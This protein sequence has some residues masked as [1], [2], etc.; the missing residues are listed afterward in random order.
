VVLYIIGKEV[1]F[2]VGFVWYGTGR[3]W[4]RMR[5][6]KEEGSMAVEGESTARA[7]TWATRARARPET[8]LDG[9]ACPRGR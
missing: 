2:I 4:A 5:K 9:E 6:P 8:N 7:R 1:K 3:L